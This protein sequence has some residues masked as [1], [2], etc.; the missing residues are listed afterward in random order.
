MLV[1]AQHGVDTLLKKVWIECMAVE[2]R[3]AIK[4]FCAK[5]AVTLAD[6]TL[7]QVAVNYDRREDDQILFN[8]CESD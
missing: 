5:N 8:E 7:M 4:P 2:I 1:C 3:Q 6:K